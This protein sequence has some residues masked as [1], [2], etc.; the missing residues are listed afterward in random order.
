M[1]GNTTRTR[2]RKTQVKP[3]AQVIELK[4]GRKECDMSVLDPS[5]ALQGL[6]GKQE[7]MALMLFQGATNLEAYEAVYDVSSENKGNKWTTACHLAAN[8]KVV[9]RVRQLQQA[10]EQVIYDDAEE[11]GEFILRETKRIANNP[12]EDT[13]DRL[14]ALEML[15]KTR[16]VMLFKDTVAIENDTRTPEQILEDITK[17]LSKEAS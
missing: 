3:I 10:K 8:P 17:A 9:A 15:G 11:L 1:T 7:A 16:H 14:K 13:K 4:D 2:K 5:K 6:T 12:N